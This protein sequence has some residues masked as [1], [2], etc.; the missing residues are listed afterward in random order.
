M[1]HLSVEVTDICVKNSFAS[2]LKQ[3]HT[4]ECVYRETQIIHRLNDT[5]FQMRQLTTYMHMYIVS[6]VTM[7]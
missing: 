4:L 2:V 3:R 1:R 5:I 6:I 7:R